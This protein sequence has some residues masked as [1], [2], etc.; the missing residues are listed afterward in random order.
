MKKW[1]LLLAVTLAAGAAQ[2]QVRFETASTDAVRE[3]AVKQGKLVFID[4]YA[5]WCPPCRMMERHVFSRKDVGDFMSQRFVAAKYDTDKPTGKELLKR[6]GNDAIPLY[7]IFDT[8]GELLGRIQG[9][10]SPEEFM[11]SVRKILKR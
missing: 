2:A 4:L 5:S 11:D 6:Y 1:I 9:A 3:M 8:K 7:L 10:S